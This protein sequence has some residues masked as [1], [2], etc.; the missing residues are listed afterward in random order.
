MPCANVPILVKRIDFVA[1]AFEVVYDQL[2]PHENHCSLPC[3]TLVGG[4]LNMA[5]RHPDYETPEIGLPE[6]GQVASTI[7]CP[8]SARDTSILF[9]DVEMQHPGCHLDERF[10]GRWA[11]GVNRTTGIARSRRPSSTGYDR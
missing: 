9:L 1:V 2:V 10:R 11:T 3:F 7:M 8:K 4:A 6:Q 5:R